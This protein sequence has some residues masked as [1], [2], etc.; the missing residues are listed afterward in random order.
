LPIRE[1]FERCGGDVE[2]PKTERCLLR[3]LQRAN[4][5]A[6]QEDH[7]RIHQWSADNWAKRP[8]DYSIRFL[9][10]MHDRIVDVLKERFGFVHKTPIHILPRRIGERLGYVTLE[11]IL[12]FLNPV[13]DRLKELSDELPDMWVVGR[14]ANEGATSEDIDILIS[15]RLN[16]MSPWF[17]EVLRNAFPE[18]L[19]DRVEFNWNPSGPLVG[20]A[21]PLGSRLVYPELAEEQEGFRERLE[22]MKRLKAIKP[23]TPFLQMKSAYRAVTDLEAFQPENIM[24]TWEAAFVN[25]H[26]IPIAVEQKFAGAFFAAHKVGKRVGLQTFSGVWRED[27]I[28]G[29]RKAIGQLG[30]KE[31]II[32]GELVAYDED[33]NPLPYKE[34]APA[35]HAETPVDDRFW[36]FHIYD[37][38][39]L[40]GRDLTGLE[41]KDRVKQLKTIRPLPDYIKRSEI[42]L[43]REPEALV[44]A[45][46]WATRKPGSEGAMLKLWEGPLSKYFLTG[47][48]RGVLKFKV[49]HEIDVE[50]VQ[51]IPKRYEKGPKKGQIIPGQWV[52][53]CRIGSK[54]EGYSIIG[55]TF[56]T[57]IDADVGDI[58]R[59]EVQM[60][61]RIG[62]KRY[63]WV[64]PRV[65]DL[66]EELREPDSY[67][68]AEKI[69]QLTWK[70]E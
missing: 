24:D 67:D 55:R 35:I 60:M 8:K 65:I 58:L 34:V 22:R 1:L 26:L 59:V 42:K 69:A 62:P 64:I 49:F 37:L 43:V 5:E 19:R 48:T 45:V 30:C 61:R 16:P 25:R 63:T 14:A 47:R 29:L 13:Y 12:D 7:F 52:Y 23:F 10:W 3:G 53:V 57:D 15:E 68:V 21:V 54:R 4:R 66:M 18:D 33:G 41:F 38:L 32:L 40:N 6:L 28:P 36:K 39:W 2:A 70:A 20:N 56:A 46:R 9:E 17:E 11:E 27:F 31:C 50:V 51:K 44:D